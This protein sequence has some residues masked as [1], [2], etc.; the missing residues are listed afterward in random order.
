MSTD[1]TVRTT[2]EARQATSAPRMRY[3]LMSSLV[4]IVLAFALVYALQP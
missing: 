2:V 4:L 1:P 3:V